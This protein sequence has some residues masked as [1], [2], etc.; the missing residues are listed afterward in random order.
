MKLEG[1]NG[2]LFATVN[3]FQL[4]LG[5]LH[6]YKGLHTVCIQVTLSNRVPLL[7]LSSGLKAFLNWKQALF[8]QGFYPLCMGQV[9]YCGMTMRLGHKKSPK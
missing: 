7:M 2:F 6:Q 3:R 1:N 5:L 8:F 4:I 9:S